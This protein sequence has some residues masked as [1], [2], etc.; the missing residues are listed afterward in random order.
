VGLEQLTSLRHS[1]ASGWLKQAAAAGLD[2]QGTI[3]LFMA[4]LR[5][6]HD[7]PVESRP[8]RRDG[9]QRRVGAA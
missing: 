9:R 8:A 6:F 7:R 2:E 4:A 3:A 5:D 1:L